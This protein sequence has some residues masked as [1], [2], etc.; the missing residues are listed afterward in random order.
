MQQ[1]QIIISL[2]DEVAQVANGARE[3][4]KK[5]SQPIKARGRSLFEP[6]KTAVSSF[7]S[8]VSGYSNPQKASKL[9]ETAK[10]L[11]ALSIVRSI[12]IRH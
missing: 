12:F 8:A 4:S 6:A 10:K 11:R 2:S 3:R 1:L 7:S 5:W 9:D